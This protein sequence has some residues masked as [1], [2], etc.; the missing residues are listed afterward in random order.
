[1]MARLVC[2]LHRARDWNQL[3]H[4]VKHQLQKEK[5][6]DQDKNQVFQWAGMWKNNILIIILRA[7]VPRPVLLY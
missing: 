3:Q 4:K 2:H 1:M 5:E 6:I 7:I